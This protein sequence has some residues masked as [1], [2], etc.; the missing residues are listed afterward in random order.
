MKDNVTQIINDFGES[1]VQVDGDIP[2]DLH[3]KDG[4][5]FLFISHDQSFSPNY[6]VGSSKDIL[7]NTTKS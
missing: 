3:A 6:H 5:R 1:I 2:F 4:D 7:K